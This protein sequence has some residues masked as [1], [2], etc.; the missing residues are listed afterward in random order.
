[1]NRIA[2]SSAILM[3]NKRSSRTA[4]MNGSVGTSGNKRRRVQKS[5]TGETTQSLAA[6]TGTY[7][8]EKFSDSFTVSHVLNLLVQG[9]N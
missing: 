3:S 1:M 9:E 8:A 6:Q 7:A 5:S 4:G 2:V